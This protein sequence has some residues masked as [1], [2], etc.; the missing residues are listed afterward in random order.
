MDGNVINAHMEGKPLGAVDAL[1]AIMDNVPFNIFV[2]RDVDDNSML[3][4]VYLWRAY[5]QPAPK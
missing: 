3:M 5:N 4:L 1:P 2:M